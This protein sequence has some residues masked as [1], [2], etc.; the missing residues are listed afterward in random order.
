VDLDARTSTIRADAAVKGNARLTAAN[1]AVLLV[2]LA[3]EG[4][5]LLGPIVVVLA[6]VLLA[7]V[8]V[9]S[10]IGPWLAVSSQ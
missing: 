5:T 2:V 4:F 7:G 3:A 10:R 8:L 1:A 9:L 6:V